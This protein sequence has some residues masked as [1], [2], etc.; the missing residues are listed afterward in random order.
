[1]P[2]TAFEVGI[3]DF[4]HPKAG[5]WFKKILQEMVD[6]GLSGWMADFGEGLPLDAKLFSGMLLNPSHQ[7]DDHDH[8]HHHFLWPMSSLSLSSSRHIIM[9]TIVIIIFMRTSSFACF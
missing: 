3:I 1:M 5:E 4:T 6:C 8:Y 7:D 2:N 9:N